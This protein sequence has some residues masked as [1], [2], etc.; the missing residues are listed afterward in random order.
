M[1]EDQERGTG[2]GMAPGVPPAV[3]AGQGGQPTGPHAEGTS[4]TGAAPGAGKAA[5]TSPAARPGT[6]GGTNAA[7][8]AAN[9]FH[10]AVKRP[11]SPH[12]G[13]WGRAQRVDPDRGA[14]REG[15]A[16]PMG[17]DG[18]E[19]GGAGRADAG[20]ADADHPGSGAVAAFGGRPARG[21]TGGDG[22]AR[23]G[24]SGEGGE[25]DG[26]AAQVPPAAFR[27]GEAGG[28]GT[29]LGGARAAAGGARTGARAAVADRAERLTVKA[30]ASDHRPTWCPG[31]G[32]FGILTALKKALVDLEIWPHEVM[33]VSGIG[34]GSKLPDYINANGFMTI[35]G[36]PL[37][38]ATGI[39]LANPKLHV[40]V[41][42]G[43]GDGYGI[44]GNHWLHT[45]RRNVD[46][47]DIV[48]NNQ[49][50]ALT[51]GQ[52]SP[53]SERGFKTTTSPTGAP[54]DP[55]LPTR[56]AFAAGASFIARGFAGQPNQLADIIAAAIRHRGY[57]LIDVL[58]PCVTFN[59]LN[60][61]DWYAERA[62]S[63]EEEGHDPT[64]PEAAW[65]KCNEWGE[66]IPIGI[67]WRNDT[68]PAYE[69]RVP[70]LPVDPPIVE[71]PLDEL[72]EEGL[73][74][75]KAEFF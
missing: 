8:G 6:P 14:G 64:D 32:D 41:V 5:G 11:A 49:I 37:A 22:L 47:V 73:E 62:Y 18:A 71:R 60:T 46:L 48:E 4:V 54:E 44:G 58:Q 34:C 63:V 9:D 57:A 55:V 15:E 3:S 51:K 29:G 26:P 66:R 10:G 13:G 30:Y 36:R 17:A 40:I 52:Y 7:T 27:G 70:G 53:T 21:G 67:L 69:E 50:Y 56:V 20:R 24:S 12:G 75:L 72:G 39:K 28:T 43:D 2:N 65:A 1:P 38:V 23:A 61:Y 25:G 42:H 74:R 16:P 45:M 68:V 31:C 19:A 59:K 33:I 35:H